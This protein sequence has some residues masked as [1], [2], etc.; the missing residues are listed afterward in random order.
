[1]VSVDDIVRHFGADASVGWLLLLLAVPALVPSPGVPLGMIFGSGLALLALH[2][3]FGPRPVR[4]PKWIARRRLATSSLD[5]ATA[6]LGPMIERLERLTRPRLAALVR[7]SVIRLLGLV[8]L[9]NAVLIILPIPLGNT[10]PAMAVMTM[11]L[12]LIARDGM[13]IVAGLGLSV[14]ALAV[15]A[16][17]VG[18]AVWLAEIWMRE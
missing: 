3:T 2:L 6:R 4:L 5:A 11:A 17:L 15:S 12:G 8:V 7:P 1:E 13:A 16:L 14:G 9:I 10:L 18:S